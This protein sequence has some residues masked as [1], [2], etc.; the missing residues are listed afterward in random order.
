MLKWINL[1]IINTF[2]YCETRKPCCRNVITCYRND[3]A[4]Y[5]HIS[6]S[7]L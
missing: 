4:C 3:A 2:H 5:R 6:T 1:F 7:G